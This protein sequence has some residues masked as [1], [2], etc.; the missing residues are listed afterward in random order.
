VNDLKSDALSIESEPAAE[1]RSVARRLLRSEFP[2]DSRRSADESAQL[3]DG[4]WTQVADAGWLS[5]GD[6]GSDWLELACILAEELGAAACPLP[7]VDVVVARQLAARAAGAVDLSGVVCAMALGAAGGDTDGGEFAVG[8]GGTVSG[9]VRYVDLGGVATHVL[10]PVGDRWALLALA[11]AGVTVRPTPGLSKPEWCDV[12]AAQAGALVFA[13]D[14]PYA[15]A[16]LWLRLGSVARA[17]GSVRRAFDLTVEHA[18]TRHQ[19]GG[20]VGRFQAVQHRLADS[21][22]SLDADGL[23]IRYAAR[24]FAWHEPDWPVLAA[25]AVSRI[26]NSARKVMRACH[27]TLA[28]V[29]FFEEH[30]APAH[31]RRVHADTLRWGI[32]RS[33]AEDLGRVLLTLP[34]GLPASDP[35]RID[36]DFRRR[37]RR[38]AADCRAEF[39]PF[40]HG[41][42]ADLDVSRLLGREHLI[43]LSWKPEDGGQG[44]PV[45]SQLAVLEELEYAGIPVDGHG[46][47]EW[48]FGPVLI[49]HGTPEQKSKLLP[50]VLAGDMV[51]C[52][53]YSEPGAGSD[54]SA[55]RSTAVRSEDGSWTIN[56]GKVFM[57]FGDTGELCMFAARTS[58]EGDPRRGISLFLV[59]MASPGIT[60]H[61]QVS[62][63]GHPACTVFFDD[64]KLEPDALLGQ[65]N[66]AWS[67]ILGSFIHE[68]L[69][70][71][72]YV[73]DLRRAFRDLVAGLS[74]GPAADGGVLRELA[75]LAADIAAAGLL[76][77]RCVEDI[78]RGQPEPAHA[79]MAKAF[80]GDLGERFAETASELLGPATLLSSE[81][82]GAGE[83]LF[84][85]W[86]RDSL[87]NVVAGG[88]GDIQRNAIAARG[89][90]LPR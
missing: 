75:V 21:A 64:V 23:M 35:L 62:F 3:L 30:E 71:G 51:V 54:L 83:G 85:W 41:H 17:Y 73:Y 5:V 59:P 60:V 46:V 89:L 6:A 58:S 12:T 38:I 37:I 77:T 43:G 32:A 19:F 24:S 90:R 53:G 14:V 57:S 56:G 26:A 4:L 70:M 52:V 20:P 16:L 28:G 82:S 61:R 86:Q 22:T 39:G 63:G 48:L 87:L 9:H 15:D 47:A 67:M 29:G 76:V 25:C 69:I 74:A 11:S 68:R 80:T 33:A 78:E 50:R 49:A 66:D 55:V 42:A 13:T 2:Y 34:D 79:A 88:T 10:A 31:F 45:R 27:R 7:L 18:K 1:L 36:P 72:S 44:E 65:V 81:P 8:P 40:G 84:E